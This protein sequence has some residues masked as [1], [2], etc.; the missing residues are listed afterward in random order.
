MTGDTPQA[1]PPPP[2]PASW[3][4]SIEAELVALR[5]EIERLSQLATKQGSQIRDVI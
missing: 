3:E 5:R 4:A 2:T 1:D